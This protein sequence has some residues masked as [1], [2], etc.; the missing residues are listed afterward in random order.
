MRSKLYEAESECE[1]LKSKQRVMLNKLASPRDSGGGGANN[2]GVFVTELAGGS[3]DLSEL[4]SKAKKEIK[5][6]KTKKAVATR[7][8]PKQ[9]NGDNE[10]DEEP[11]GEE[12]E[13]EQQQQQH[14]V[15]DEDDVEDDDEDD[16]EDEDDE[17]EQD[18]IEAANLSYTELAQLTQDISTKQR[19]IEELENSQLRLESLKQKYEEKLA[20]L[21][22]KIRCTEEER[23]AVLGKSTSANNKSLEYENKIVALQRELKKVRDRRLDLI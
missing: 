7:R 21:T 6:E 12:E 17:E 9:R 10:D 23:D 5:L 1:K 11:Q 18:D 14:D 3:G 4:L 15:E 20:Q 16:D 19:L 2:S 13:E 8:A 22:T